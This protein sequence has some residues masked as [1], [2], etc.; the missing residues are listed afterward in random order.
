MLFL[1]NSFNCAKKNEDTIHSHVLQL[2][3]TRIMQKFQMWCAT[4]IKWVCMMR[5]AAALQKN[6]TIKQEVLGILG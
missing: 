5:S 1:K 4:L 2:F 6:K 3:V